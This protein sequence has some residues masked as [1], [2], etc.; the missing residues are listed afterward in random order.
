MSEEQHEA[1]SITTKIR[2][3]FEWK[4]L[5]REEQIGKVTRNEEKSNKCSGAEIW[6]EYQYWWNVHYI[7]SYLHCNHQ[8]RYL[9]FT[10]TGSGY[11]IIVMQG[12]KKKVL[13]KVLPCVLSLYIYFQQTECCQ[14]SLA[15]IFPL[16]LKYAHTYI[17]KKWRLKNLQLIKILWKY[18]FLLFAFSLQ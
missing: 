15:K 12:E 8:D 17:V 3:L 6:G 7:F 4:D 10:E 5:H 2:T 14:Y 11:K 16:L 1:K 18:G 9:H 13:C